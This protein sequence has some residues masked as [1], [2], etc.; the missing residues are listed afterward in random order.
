MGLVHHAR[1]FPD[2]GWNL[3]PLQWKCRVL[4]TGPP[5]KS[6]SGHFSLK[7]GFV[8]WS[9]WGAPVLD[10]VSAS[11]AQCHYSAL[12]AQSDPLFAVPWTVPARLLSLWNF[13][14]KNTE[15]GCHALL[16]GIFPVWELNLFAFPALAGE[17]FTS[18][19]TWEAMARYSPSL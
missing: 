9:R 3:R 5:G 14:G 8:L 6:Q 1:S 4:T 2:Q 11:R 15:M 16:Q 18:E 12:C 7:A 19:P 10:G 17:F 13:P